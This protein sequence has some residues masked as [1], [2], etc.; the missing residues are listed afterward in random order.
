MLFLIKLLI[1]NQTK[2]KR[3]IFHLILNTTCHNIMLI[4]PS[5]QL[6]FCMEIKQNT[7]LCFI[8]G[9]SGYVL[10]SQVWCGGRWCLCAP[11]LQHPL[12]LR[13]QPYN[14]Y[15]LEQS[16]L[17]AQEGRGIEDGVDKER[18]R[19]KGGKRSREGKQRGGARAQKEY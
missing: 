3:N 2:K 15:N 19:K 8:K 6:V 16:L 7:W 14:G 9:E 13:Y 10:Q 12:S 11:M 17:R 5:R 18:K 1:P 4:L